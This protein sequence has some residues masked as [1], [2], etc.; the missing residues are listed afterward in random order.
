MARKVDEKGHRTIGVITK[1]DIMD[2]GTNARNML[3]G[4]DVKLRL[5]FVG[6]KNRSQK[7]IIDMVPVKKALAIE[8]E[9]FDNHPTYRDMPPGFLGIGNLTKKLTKILFTHIK[10]NLPTITQEIKEKIRAT[11]SD[12][13]DLGNPMPLD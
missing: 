13:R 5:G 11:E 8:K 12:L 2:A 4:R 7:D 1:L 9:W 3:E 6:I 10:V